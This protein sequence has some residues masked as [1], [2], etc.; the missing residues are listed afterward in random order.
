MYD[1]MHLPTHFSSGPP[2]EM[3]T[4][5]ARGFSADLAVFART[6]TV[7]TERCRFC[8]AQEEGWKKIKSRAR[9]CSGSGFG[10]SSVQFR[11]CFLMVR[12]SR[13]FG[14]LGHSS[15]FPKP[16]CVCLVRSRAECACPLSCVRMSCSHVVVDE[17]SARGKGRVAISGGYFKFCFWCSSFRDVFCGSFLL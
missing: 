11:S 9:P 4:L 17:S 15:R 3:K 16:D 12:F 5:V 14:R 13:I 7:S 8:S 6:S 10:H 2:L 1:S